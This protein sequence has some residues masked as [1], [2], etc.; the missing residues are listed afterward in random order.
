MATFGLLRGGYFLSAE[1]KLIFRVVLTAFPPVLQRA[2]KRAAQRNGWS[3]DDKRLHVEIIRATLAAVPNLLANS[4]LFT[5][6]TVEQLIAA[7]GQHQEQ[8]V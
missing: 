2:V 7:Y 8:A 1:P 5:P 6:A 4:R 3:E